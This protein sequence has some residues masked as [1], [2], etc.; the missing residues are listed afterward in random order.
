MR[1]SNRHLP[2]IAL[3]I[4]LVIVFAVRYST[5]MHRLDMGQDI[6]N[7]LSTMNAFFGHDTTGMGLLRP[8]LLVLPLKLFTMVFGSLTGVKVLGVLISV[9]LGIPF[10]LLARRICHP[11]IAVAV[12]ILFVFT[13]AYSSMLTWGYITM[14]GIFFILLTCHFLLLMLEHPSKTNVILTGISASMIAGFHQLSLAFFLP[15]LVLFIV[16]LVVF[17]WD[18]LR[19]TCRPLAMAMAI[20]VILSLP[21]LPIYLRLLHLQSTAGAA[22][23]ISIVSLNQADVPFRYL[24]WVCGIVFASTVVI[25][26]LAWLWR[27]DRNRALMIGTML[28]AALALSLFHPPPPYLELSRRAHFYMYIP[29]WLIAG[30][31][32]SRLWSWHSVHSL[33]RLRWLPKATAIVLIIALLTSGI[34]WSQRQLH[35]GLN[36]FGYLDNTRWGAVQWIEKNT[37]PEALIA[38]YP[39]ILG[40]WIEADAMRTTWRV[41]DR[42]MTPYHFERDQSLAADR[43]LSRNQGLENGNLRLAMTYP[44]DGIP[45]NPV[46]GVY[47]GGMYQ[48]ILMFD[49]GQ[50]SLEIPGA[51]KLNMAEVQN[52]EVS[53]TGDSESMQ[54]SASYYWNGLRVTQTVSLHRG[55]QDAT[56]SFRFSCGSGK[57]T[58]FHIPIL[59]CHQPNSALI[60]ASEQ[61]IEVTQEFRTV[62]DGVVPTTARVGVEVQ[63]ASL[64]KI[65]PS[66][67]QVDLSFDMGGSEATVTFNISITA[68][69]IRRDEAVVHY[70]VP[71]LIRDQTIGYVAVDL[72][73][74]S[75]LWTDMPSATLEWLN[76][77]PYY[78]LAYSQGDIRIYQVD[79]GA[80]P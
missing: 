25:V 78:R 17:S 61:S 69:E 42:D 64:D 14:T 5:V 65:N 44:Y 39:D 55:L 33:G 1:S 30:V 54:I 76:N 51:G 48:D 71:D 80:L 10:Y 29:L 77:C 20:A 60:D 26:G 8:P 28:L 40:W 21:Y 68:P 7:Y 12:S 19:Q 2:E 36:F 53:T 67:R 73:P 11:W 24:P 31:V 49:N 38:L 52:R 57:M 13:P 63:G 18:R 41:A 56:I 22:P 6:A 16:A 15:A 4:S 72:S 9:A 45:G 47:V 62:F 43:I 50:N 35:R 23:S 3:L 37:P 75:P 74:H 46:L 34:M 79:A 58:R 70:E 32:L 66:A 59:F 27:Q